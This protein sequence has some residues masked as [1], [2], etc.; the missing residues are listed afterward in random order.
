[1]KTKKFKLNTVKPHTKYI[2]KTNRNKQN[3]GY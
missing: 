3:K 2:H 1:M